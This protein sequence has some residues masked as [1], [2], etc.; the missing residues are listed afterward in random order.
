MVAADYAAMRADVAKIGLG[1]KPGQKKPAKT[2][3]RK[4]AK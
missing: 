3:A 1:R 4:R 2:G